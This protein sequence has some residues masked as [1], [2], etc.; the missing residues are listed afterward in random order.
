MSENRKDINKCVEINIFVKCKDGSWKKSDNDETCVK[1][2]IHVDCKECEK[3][4][5]WDCD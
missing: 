3:Q 1:V 5:M 2:N 4:K